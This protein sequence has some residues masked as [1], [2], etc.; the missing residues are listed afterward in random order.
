MAKN[1]SVNR[2]IEGKKQK[3]VRNTHLKL[4]SVPQDSVSTPTS[5]LSPSCYSTTSNQDS[6]LGDLT[7]WSKAKACH[8]SSYNSYSTF[9]RGP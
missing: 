7:I 3:F 2:V 4:S 6:F 1:D 9:I 8:I 5:S